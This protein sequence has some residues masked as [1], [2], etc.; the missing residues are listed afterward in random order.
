MKI[1]KIAVVITLAVALVLGVTL[2]GL[3]ASDAVV[4]QASNFTSSDEP[5]AWGKKFPRIVRGEVSEIG[6]ES[7]A[8]QTMEEPIYVNE[9]TKYFMV[10]A[11]QIACALHRWRINLGQ[12]RVENAEPPTPARGRPFPLPWL[13]E[14]RA[15]QELTLFRFGRPELAPNLPQPGNGEGVSQGI[16]AK[17]KWL[18]H[19][20]EEATFAD[21]EVGDKVV[22]LLVPGEDK[23]TAKVVLIIKP[24]VWGRIIGTITDVS[25]NFIT[26]EPVSGGDE[27]PLEYTENTIFILK[28]IIGIDEEAEQFACALYN[29]ETMIARV[30]RVWP[31]APQPPQPAE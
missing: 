9:G 23:P 26:I 1:W 21:M 7:F 16:G 10:S 11:P 3:A 29:T 24:S 2:P 27:I 20:G 18:R 25:G 28:G 12:P 19:F 22:A 5:P 6:G 13:K 30:V 17:L 15:G 31:E 4:T 14:E 8:I